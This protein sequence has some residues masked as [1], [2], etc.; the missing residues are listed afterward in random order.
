MVFHEWQAK[1]V[2]KSE[3]QS[4]RHQLL[5]AGT[6]TTFVFNHCKKTLIF[7]KVPASASECLESWI[8]R[9]PLLLTCDVN[10]G[11]HYRNKSASCVI[12]S[13][14]LHQL[15]LVQMWGF[16]HKALP[17]CLSPA[18]LPNAGVGASPP[19]RPACPHF[20]PAACQAW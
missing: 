11:K 15:L 6:C 9:I 5:L 10:G 14:H 13:H 12:R 1:T 16:L 19:P 20:W 7:K 4:A 2:Q 17:R 3:R 8:P 18:E